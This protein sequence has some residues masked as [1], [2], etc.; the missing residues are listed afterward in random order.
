MLNNVEEKYKIYKR[1]NALLPMEQHNVQIQDNHT[2]EIKQCNEII[3]LNV[4][5]TK[6]EVLKSN[7]AYWPT[8]RLSQLVRARTDDEILKYCDGFLAATAYRKQE[9]YFQQNWINFNSILD[10]LHD[11]TLLS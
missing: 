4:G 8:T 7:F 2:D 10:M 11:K 5:G 9:Y 3:V 1:R 6:H